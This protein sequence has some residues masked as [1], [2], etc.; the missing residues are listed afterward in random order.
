MASNF[1]VKTSRNIGTT[2]TTIGNYTVPLT[3]QTTAIGL[4]VSNVLPAN[5]SISVNVALVS[6]T[7]KTYIVQD[8]AVPDGGAL[9][10]IGGDQKVVM[11]ANYSIQVS[12]SNASAAD[13]I[14]SILE[15]T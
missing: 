4:V 9:I 15:L 13:A 7:D 3:A 6:G 10:C 1:Y 11:E 12:A 2:W 5:T 8:A 14:L